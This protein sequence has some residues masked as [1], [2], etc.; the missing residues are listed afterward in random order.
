MA[1]ILIVGK[2]GFG[3]MIPLWDLAAELQRRGHRLSVA[4]EAHHSQACRALDLDLIPLSTT[5]SPFTA[6]PDSEIETLVPF[7]R[8]ADLLLG[9]QLA[10][11]P[12][13]LGALTGTPWSYCT[14]SPLA[15]PS[16]YDLPWWPGLQAIQRRASQSRFIQDTAY[17]LARA[18][19]RLVMQAHQRQRR[20]FGLKDGAHPRFEALYSPRLNLLMTS[21]ILVESQPD[22]P[23]H[24]HVTGFCAYE[25]PFLGSP[26]E[27]EAMQRFAAAGP[28]PL[29]IAPGGRDRAQPAHMANACL[30]ACRQLGQRAVV[31][32]NTRFHHLIPPAPDILVTGYMPYGTLIDPMRAVI[33]SG[34][35][36]T[37]GWT[38][39]LNKPSL[40]LPSVWDQFD[41]ARRATERGLALSLPTR[42]SSSRIAQSM[43]KLLSAP[44]PN[45]E[46]ASRAIATEQGATIAAD[47]IETLLR[48]L[49]R[50]KIAESD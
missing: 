14:A 43:E 42:A 25:A 41:N 28:P 50:S 1:T 49:E 21:P 29:L 16:H 8:D 19:T 20:R 2:G 48:E 7:A 33:H 30:A 35:I 39:R 23:P 36:G 40:L 27:T 34:G 15:L 31:L 9:N 12:P 26:E 5:H 46:S 37:I 18:A 47:A 32:L 44:W 4:A 6:T 45:L 3:D 38:L 17:R 24:T 10:S 22:W 13:I 11:T